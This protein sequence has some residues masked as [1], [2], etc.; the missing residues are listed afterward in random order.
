MGALGTLHPNGDMDLA[1]T[2]RT[3]AVADGR[4]HLWVGGG[5]VVH[6]LEV[7]GWG[8]PAHWIHDV[9][10][11]AAAALPQAAGAVAWIVTA[12]LDGVFGLV[13]GLAIIPV[14]KHLI[15]PLAG[16]FSRRGRA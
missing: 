7:F 12:A 8:A 3:F 14:A 11:G 15:E 9:A 10:E 13:L 16:L 2:I 5:I 4:I 1:L 6:G